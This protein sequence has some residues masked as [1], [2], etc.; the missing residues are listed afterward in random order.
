MTERQGV[1]E[2]IAAA[3][4]VYVLFGYLSHTTTTASTINISPERAILLQAGTMP[5]YF[6]AKEALLTPVRNQLG[7][8]S[9][10]AFSVCEMLADTVSLACGGTWKEHL[11]PQYLLSCTNVHYGC[12][13]GGSP[14]DVYSIPELTLQGIPLEKDMP[15]VHSVTTCP[16]V[17]QNAMRIR[18]VA[19]TGI[20]ICVDPATALPGFRQA[21]INKNIVNMKRALLQYGPICATLR[22]TRELYDYKGDCIYVENPDSPTLGEHCVC[23]YG[24][25]DKN[26]NTHEPGFDESYWI[27]KNSYSTA[28]A[29]LLYGFAYIKMGC[30]NAQIESRA[31]VCEVQIPEFLKADS[32]KHN[33]WDSYYT[34]YGEYASDKNKQNFVDADRKRFLDDLHKARVASQKKIHPF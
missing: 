24:W 22:I 2:C 11:A 4:V 30:N 8:A 1:V 3:C 16:T 32:A 12:K 7:C 14:E 9:C 34:S 26:A 10:W 31:S 21:I 20:D 25:S 28:W 13:L 23:L 15:Y 6:K 19:N 18:T 5:S 29:G 27:I 17:P 33:V